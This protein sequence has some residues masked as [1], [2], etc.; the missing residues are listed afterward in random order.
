MNLVS[1]NDFK[2]TFPQKR[3]F[4]LIELMVTISV[5]IIL[6]TLG[7]PSFV[8]FVQEYSA[9]SAIGM[10][11]K[12]LQLARAEAVSL[13]KRIT[14]C[15]LGSNG[16]C[17]GNWLEGVSVFVDDEEPIGTLNSD[18]LVLAQSNPMG[19]ENTFL[20]GTRD[21]VTFNSEGQ[22]PGFNTTFVFCPSS[23]EAKY[24]KG[25][26][27]SGTGRARATRDDDND[28]IHEKSDGTPLSC[29]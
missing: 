22:S 24:A 21:R 17:D 14:V 26:I 28:G 11:H 4:T 10:F 3:G 7:V 29:G 13:G 1:D 15:H 25:V 6:V 20:D 19:S 2:R 23:G 9:K 16:E 27:L 18:E 12:D 8:Q 5:L